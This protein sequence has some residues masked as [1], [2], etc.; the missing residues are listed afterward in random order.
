M[1]FVEG[2]GGGKRGEKMNFFVSLSSD[3]E[4]ENTRCDN[5]V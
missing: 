1:S 2:G 5:C 4:V 3:S